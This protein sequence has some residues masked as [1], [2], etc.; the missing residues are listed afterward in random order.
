MEGFRM[1]EEFAS[2]VSLTSKSGLN[3]IYP[4]QDP[5]MISFTGGF[6]DASLFPK[7]ELAQSFQSAIMSKPAPLQYQVGDESLAL[8]K[9]IATL[10][11]NDGTPTDSAFVMMTQGAQQGLDLVAKL[12]INKGDGLVVEGPT[13]I[14]ALAAFD[15]YEPTYYS[16]GMQDD[17]MNLSDLKKILIQKSVKMIYTIPDFQNPTGIVMSMEKRRQLIA[18]AN[19]Y[20]VIILEDAPYRW[21]RYEGRSLPSLKALDTQSRVIQLGSFSKILAPGLRLGWL[22][23]GNDLY[24]RLQELKAA[25]D[26]ETSNIMIQTV[27]A[28]LTDYSLDAHLRKLQQSY[29]VKRDAMMQA[30][31]KYLPAQASYSFP[32][33]GFFTWVT[34]PDG[35]DFEKAQTR[36]LLPNFHVMVIPAT[37]LFPGDGHKNGARVSFSTVSLSQI[38]SGIKRLGEGLSVGS[39]KQSI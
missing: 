20:D 7:E 26:L 23:A 10:L 28:Y 37:H 14:G 31:Q 36:L 29:R 12:L 18:L 4:S 25:S 17:G 11:T 21:L 2:R 15:A 39:Q 19:K 35:F 3:A 5:E 9:K 24:S 34:M 16:V 32:K 13:Y 6:P 1:E 33:G 30:M 22:T 27:N 38:D 8:R